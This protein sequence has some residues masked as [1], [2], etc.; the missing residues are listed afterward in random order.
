MTFYTH[1]SPRTFLTRINGRELFAQKLTDNRDRQGHNNGHDQTTT[2]IKNK[3]R[4]DFFLINS[5]RVN[6]CLS[7]F[8]FKQQWKECVCECVMDLSNFINQLKLIYYV[9]FLMDKSKK[10]MSSVLTIND[11]KLLKDVILIILIS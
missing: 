3:V 9:C 10:D 5:G 6:F 1:F 2:R 7:L 4:C 11:L 8:F